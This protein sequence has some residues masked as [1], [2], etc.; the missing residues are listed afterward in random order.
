M[1]NLIAQIAAIHKQQ[2]DA[3]EQM[4]EVAQGMKCPIC[5]AGVTRINS[6]HNTEESS[7]TLIVFKCGC[8]LLINKD[9]SEFGGDCVEATKAWLVLNAKTNGLIQAE[10]KNLITLCNALRSVLYAWRDADVL[11]TTID[12][13]LYKHNGCIDKAIALLVKAE[14]IERN[15]EEPLGI[16]N[17]TATTKEKPATS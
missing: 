14:S 11:N 2:T 13:V 3:S 8:D 6:T 4:R 16:E 17:N 1:E 9:G 7:G 10:R 15:P 5:S 12:D